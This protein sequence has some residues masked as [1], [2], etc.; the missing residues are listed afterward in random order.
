[1]SKLAI[2]TNSRISVQRKQY[3]ILDQSTRNR[4]N[5]QAIEQLER[6]NFHDDPHAN[7]VMHKKAPKFDEFN[8]R[9]KAAQQT[10]FVRKNNIKARSYTLAMLIEEDSRN[11]PPNYLSIMTRS[12]SDKSRNYTNGQ[13][14]PS[15]SNIS[16]SESFVPN[17]DG[18][19]VRRFFCSVCGFVGTYTCIVCGLRYCSS[20][21]QNTHT[22]TRCLKWTG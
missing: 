13:S 17:V 10:T 7:L 22:E 1:M 11:P 14:S 5:R 6:D 4:R 9:P 18:R 12:V 16:C 8:Q 19:V 2:K 15:S 3:R 21:C 20:F